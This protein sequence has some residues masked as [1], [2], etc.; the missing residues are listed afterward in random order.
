VIG[1]RPHRSR[2][3]RGMKAMPT[4]DFAIHKTLALSKVFS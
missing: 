2:A 4:R 3:K 1:G